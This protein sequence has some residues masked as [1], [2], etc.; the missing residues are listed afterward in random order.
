MSRKTVAL[1]LAATGLITSLAGC[2]AGQDAN[3]RGG[4]EDKT[5]QPFPSSERNRDNGG[6]GDKRDEGGEGGEGEDSDK[7]DQRDKGD[8]GG[9]GGE[10]D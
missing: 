7:R 9:E 3:E 5:G 2:G 8:E 6:A 4:D 1:F 10:G